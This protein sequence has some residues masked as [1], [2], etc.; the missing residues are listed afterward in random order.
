MIRVMRDDHGYSTVTGQDALKNGQKTLSKMDQSKKWNKPKQRVKN[1][2]PAHD[3]FDMPV[4]LTEYANTH[5][6]AFVEEFLDSSFN[7]LFS[8]IRRAIER[9]AE[10]VLE[11]HKQQFF[12]LVSWFLEAER[13]R[14]ESK[15]EAEKQQKDKKIAETFEADSFALIASVLNQESFILLNRFMQDRLDMRS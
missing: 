2:E 10:R 11:A 8:H 4:A 13:V 1:E 14:R 6:R 12:Y 3:R 15:N 5:L 7:P 9:E